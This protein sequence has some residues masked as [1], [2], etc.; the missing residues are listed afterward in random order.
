[1]K[2]IGNFIFAG[3]ATIGVMNTGLFEVDRILEI[4]DEIVE[5]NAKDYIH[6]YPEIPVVVPSEWESEGYR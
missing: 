6:N 2:A 4:T 1:M 5:Q 3:S